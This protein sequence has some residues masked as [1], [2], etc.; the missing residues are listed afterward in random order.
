MKLFNGG[1]CSPAIHR[2]AVAVSALT[3]SLSGSLPAVAAGLANPFPEAEHLS[4]DEISQ[5]SAAFEQALQAAKPGT[6]VV[7]KSAESGRAGQ[8]RV[9]RAWDGESGHCVELEQR[10][11]KGNKAVYEVP[12]CQGQDGSWK[13]TF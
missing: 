12:Y 5:I 1:Y 3:I 7:W 8:V 10:F 11:N 9:L 6:V 4:Q 2:I 13:V